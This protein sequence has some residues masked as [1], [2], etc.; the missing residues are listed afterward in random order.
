MFEE[1][2][3]SSLGRKSDNKCDRS[4]IRGKSDN[5]CNDNKC[6]RSIIRG[7]SDNKCDQIH[8]SFI[9]VQ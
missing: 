6:D 3:T 9:M 4:V 5:K 8:I 1:Y 7:K 2:W